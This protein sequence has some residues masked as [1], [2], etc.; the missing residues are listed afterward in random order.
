MQLKA[1]QAK[2]STRTSLFSELMTEQA[3]TR[4]KLKDRISELEAENSRLGAESSTMAI[5]RRTRSSRS[6]SL[7]RGEAST[8]KDITKGARGSRFLDPD[9]SLQIDP[10]VLEADTSFEILPQISTGPGG[11][12]STTART[13]S[14]DLDKNSGAGGS[15]RNGAA[16]CKYFSA[17][18]DDSTDAVVEGISGRGDHRSILI[19]DS[20][21][22]K[23]ASPKRSR[24]NPFVTTR[25]Q[26]DA[27]KRL[28]DDAGDVEI[29]VLRDDSP[30]V[31]EGN[32]KRGKD[33]SPPRK[34]QTRSASR[35]PLAEILGIAD[36]RG[37][38]QKGVASGV[39][40]KRRA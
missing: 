14:F 31:D 33:G 16:T 19:R 30:P 26:S 22:P 6:A 3:E 32:K 1:F 12:R 20:S 35:K 34:R 4:H 27:K 11:S 13:Y 18:S 28:R 38:P 25:Q 39:K 7:Q 9:E 5:S 40:A 36:S 17:G 21:S 2:V 15:K 24:T 29:I 10:P 8:S 37:V 23:P